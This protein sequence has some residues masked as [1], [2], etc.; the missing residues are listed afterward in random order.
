M[1]VQVYAQH[2]HSPIVLVDWRRP[3]AERSP[4]RD[5][6]VLQVLHNV[7]ASKLIDLGLEAGTEPLIQNA[8]VIGTDVEAQRNDTAP[9]IW[10]VEAQPTGDAQ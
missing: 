2:M 10:C 4:Q 5:I 7:V 6:K 3:H 8:G 9:R 1:I